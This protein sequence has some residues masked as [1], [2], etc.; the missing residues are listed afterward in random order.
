[1]DADPHKK[2]MSLISHAQHQDDT[3]QSG[4]MSIPKAGGKGKG[5]AC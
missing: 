2:I 4:R 1:M 5:F 3:Y